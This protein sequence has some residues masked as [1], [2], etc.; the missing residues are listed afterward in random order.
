MKRANVYL[1]SQGFDFRIR[2][3]A[4]REPG[5]VVL[6]RTRPYTDEF[7]NQYWGNEN[8]KDG[9]YSIA[10]VKTSEL[11]S[12]LVK[13]RGHASAC[14]GG[15]RSMGWQ[16]YS[17]PYDGLFQGRMNFKPP[18]LSEEQAKMVMDLIMLDKLSR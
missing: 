18:R 12:Q 1:K 3:S 10:K 11:Q 5:L 17:S 8:L 2:R 7:K 15:H 14:K 6:Y 4:G 16:Q 13:P 9:I